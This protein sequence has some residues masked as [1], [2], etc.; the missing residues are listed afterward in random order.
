MNVEQAMSEYEEK[1][2][3]W[4]NEHRFYLENT[5]KPMPGIGELTNLRQLTCLYELRTFSGEVVLT[6]Q[7]Y[8]YS[9]ALNFA[10]NW[11]KDLPKELGT[12]AET[13][14]TTT[15]NKAKQEIADFYRKRVC[16]LVESTK[17]DEMPPHENQLPQNWMPFEFYDYWESRVAQRSKNATMSQ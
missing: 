11:I 9:A 14:R 17:W 7:D 10:Q 12:L 5:S 4:I 15:D 13:F 1:M 16:W 3:I 8:S 2:D 6:L